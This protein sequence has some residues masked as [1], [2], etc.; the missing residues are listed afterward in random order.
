MWDTL[1][2]LGWGRGLYDGRLVW[3]PRARVLRDAE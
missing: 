1:V 3:L 2:G